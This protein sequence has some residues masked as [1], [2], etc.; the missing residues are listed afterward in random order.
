MKD[1]EINRFLEMNKYLLE[2]LREG[3]KEVQRVL[4][5]QNTLREHLLAPD[6]HFDIFRR[7]TR[8]VRASIVNLNMNS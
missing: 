3:L 4:H 6:V 5:L 8:R 1:L 7:D 2:K